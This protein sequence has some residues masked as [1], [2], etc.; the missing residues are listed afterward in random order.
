MVAV[1][2]G[3]LP[4]LV[5]TG[6]SGFVGRA[7]LRRIAES[8]PA[9]DVLALVRA[10]EALQRESWWQSG[11][12]ARAWDPT[13]GVQSGPWRDG[14]VVIHLAAATGAATTAEMFAVNLDGTVAA[15]EAAHRAECRH[16]VFVSSIAAGYQDQRWYPYAQA[17]R[18]A[19][20][21]VEGGSVPWT[22]LR[23]TFV[24]GAG[25][26]V[27]RSLM[28]LARLPVIPGAGQVHTQP[29][30]V[31]DLV[32]ALLGLLRV[33]PLRQ[34]ADVGGPQS[35]RMRA[36]LDL[37][38]HGDASQPKWRLHLPLTILR[39]LLAVAERIAP[40]LPV[41]AGQ[42]A[43]FVNDSRV[44]NPLPEK[45]FAPRITLTDMVRSDA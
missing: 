6:A 44:R 9:T 8:W 27:Q 25:S 7:L 30:H 32:D 23:P 5:V 42:F 3:A 28:R 43:A 40:R 13:R 10:P 4:P 29:I 26:S 15:L 36:L 12:V 24:F 1:S 18:E 39:P 33:A 38:A 22:I 31:D 16:F 34:V 35:L 19:E 41:T 21:R 14:A 2:L 17:K 11:W 45:L 20:R 37:M